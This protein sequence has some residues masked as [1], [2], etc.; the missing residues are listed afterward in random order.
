MYSFFLKLF[1]LIDTEKNNIIHEHQEKILN[2]NGI[3]IAYTDI[4]PKSGKLVFCVHG[5]L[6][7][8]RDFDFLGHALAQ[9][10]Y[11]CIAIDL[12]GRG[13]SSNFAH[14]SQY[15]P[16]NYLPYCLALLEYEAPGQEFCWV[17]VSL[18]GILGMLLS[19]VLDNSLQHN[20][21]KLGQAFIDKIN[22]SSP[23][24][25]IQNPSLDLPKFP[26]HGNFQNKGYMPSFAA[27]SNLM[28]HLVLVDIGGEI[29]AKGMDSIADIANIPTIY[30]KKEDAVTALKKR[31]VEWGINDNKFWDHLI[32]HNIIDQDD[33]TYVFSYD[34][35]IVSVFQPLHSNETLPMWN[36]WIA[37]KQPT[38]LIRGGKSRILPDNI[39]R[40][41]HKTYTGEYFEEIIYGDCGHVPNL[42]QDD[43]VQE[44][45][46]WIKKY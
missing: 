36:L 33:G 37:V 6:S 20:A 31:C 39:A 42:M 25:N 28:T 32:K 24:L 7:T 22:V 16:P 19:S 9:Q 43:H 21:V 45:T 29:S 14:S 34:K 44:L 23:M 41:M 11:R 15:V 13:R 46:S 40:K 38:L 26:Q 18:G 17:G 8:G 4:G 3:D 1:N 27:I 10:G 30:D 35:E 12:P 2:I 5:L